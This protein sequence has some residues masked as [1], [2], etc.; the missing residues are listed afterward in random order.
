[1][2]Q[3]QFAFLR[4]H[5]GRSKIPGACRGPSVLMNEEKFSAEVGGVGWS[6]GRWQDV[7]VVVGEGP[8]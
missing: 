4:L 8:L 6:V 5:S 2:N 7:R 1:M 3:R